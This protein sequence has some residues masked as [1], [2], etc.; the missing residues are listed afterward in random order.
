MTNPQRCLQCH[1]KIA[2]PIFVAIIVVFKMTIW[3]VCFF[4]GLDS[5]YSGLP[6]DCNK[7]YL[8]VQIDTQIQRMN[9]PK[10]KILKFEKGFIL[11]H[12]KTLLQRIGI[13][14]QYLNWTWNT[15]VLYEICKD[16]FL[17]QCEQ[18]CNL[19]QDISKSVNSII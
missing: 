12:I 8:Q 5:T 17:L 7:L 3:H 9:S 14:S 2:F 19:F 11:V 6:Y 4:L 10:V 15:I 1:M 18:S 16:Q 13:D